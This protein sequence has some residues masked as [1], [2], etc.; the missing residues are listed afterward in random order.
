MI[1]VG[2]NVSAHRLGHE[3]LER[4]R[5]HYDLKGARVIG[6]FGRLTAQRDFSV[7]IPILAQAK[8]KGRRV[9]L[10]LIGWMESSNPKFFRQLMDLARRKGVDKQII[11][12][13]QLSSESVSHHL[14]LADIFLYP[15]REGISARST[16]LMSA[17]SHGLPVVAYEPSCGNAEGFE[18]PVC[19]LA[20][21][22]DKETLREKAFQFFKELKQDPA[23]G[24]PNADFFK[25]YF[26]WYEIADQYR[27]TFF[28][29]LSFKKV[30]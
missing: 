26:T 18:I 13:G 10:L 28:S 7:A 27:Q 16:T 19:G 30:A 3:D 6:G 8:E 11:V 24:S 17:L 23:K 1:P 20:P 5:D 21:R 15:E 14:Q 9:V 22:G 29:D 4:L 12:T 25:R 2:D